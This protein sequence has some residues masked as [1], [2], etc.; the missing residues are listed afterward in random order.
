MNS[1]IVDDSVEIPTKCRFVVKFI[2]PKFLKVQH[3]SSGTPLIIRSSKL[4]LQSLV[5]R[6]YGDRSLSRLNGD[7]SAGNGRPPYE[8][9][10]Q[11]LQIQFRAPDDERCAA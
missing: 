8:H 10:N 9:I 5:Y 11:R 1:C 7:C 2:I 4:Y 6:P 3:V